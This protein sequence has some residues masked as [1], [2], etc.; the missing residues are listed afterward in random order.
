MSAKP[1]HPLQ[2]RPP[3]ARTARTPRPATSAV[4]R[5]SPPHP[6]TGPEVQDVAA[7]LDPPDRDAFQRILAL[8]ENHLGSPEA[9]RLWL[10]TPSSEFVGTPLTAVTQGRAKL[11]L[12][13]LESRWGSGPAHA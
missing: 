8:L 7:T 12:A 3:V 11:V 10:V 1:R 6:P 5:R 4:R 9:A 2:A 13:L